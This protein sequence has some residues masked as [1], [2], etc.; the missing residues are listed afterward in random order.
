MFTWLLSLIYALGYYIWVGLK[1]T[2]IWLWQ[3]VYLLF[4]GVYLLLYWIA[5][6]LA[7]AVYF[8]A[9]WLDKI[10]SAILYPFGFIISTKGIRFRG[11]LGVF[12]FILKFIWGLIL[13]VFTIA[14]PLANFGIW[15]SSLPVKTKHLFATAT[16]ILL[17]LLMFILDVNRIY[18]STGGL[19]GSIN[20]YYLA[21]PS[22]QV[23]SINIDSFYKHL[24]DYMLAVDSE[25]FVFNLE[26]KLEA[27]PSK[28]L[29]EMPDQL[30]RE[31]SIVLTL[32]K[33][34]L[35]KKT[36]R[37][38]LSVDQ[39]KEVFVSDIPS[40]GAQIHYEKI[41]AGYRRGKKIIWFS[42]EGLLPKDYLLAVETLIKVLGDRSM[43]P[44]ILF[45]TGEPGVK[46]AFQSNHALMDFKIYSCYERRPQAQA[47]FEKSIG[48]KLGISDKVQLEKLSAEFISTLGHDYHLLKD[49][50]KGSD[51]SLSAF[52]TKHSAL[53]KKHLAY[54]NGNMKLKSFLKMIS[55]RMI[56]NQ[57]TRENR[58]IEYADIYELKS[59]QQHEKLIEE[60][61]RDGILVENMNKY[62]FKNNA[63]FKYF[64]EE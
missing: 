59:T 48:Y 21:R 6:G 34:G 33:L 54:L 1:I 55:R 26:R 16:T 62:R 32:R 44:F 57:R 28:I 12:T 29:L 24:E 4:Y 11:L 27:G 41:K 14:L 5:Y 58:W 42:A 37:I 40:L 22:T 60:S 38:N 50:S 39:K 64:Y 45:S 23:G 2:G 18:Y 52:L 30:L 9:I 56:A 8:I 51:V 53:I 47:F 20:D 7:M 36:Q 46:R 31:E 13:W 43:D 61:L 25:G 3:Y 49:F 63:Y 15:K 35:E 17:G 19:S 10:L